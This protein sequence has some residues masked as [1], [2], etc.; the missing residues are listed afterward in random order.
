MSSGARLTAGNLQ[1]RQFVLSNGCTGTAVNP[2][3][4][5]LAGCCVPKG[6]SEVA[7]HPAIHQSA[8]TTFWR[9]V[10]CLWHG[11]WLHAISH[12]PPRRGITFPG[13][14]RALPTDPTRL[15]TMRTPR[16]HFIQNIAPIFLW[17]RYGQIAE[18]Q[19]GICIHSI[20]E[21]MDLVVSDQ[22]PNGSRCA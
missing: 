14:G 6:R 11:T 19:I 4:R 8:A 15:S 1:A 21:S 7:A 10:F 2:C 20:G 22:K 13:N 16:G 17:A 9:S 5:V 18:S 3:N 12:R